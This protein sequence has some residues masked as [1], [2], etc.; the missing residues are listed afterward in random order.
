MS[1]PLPNAAFD[2]T[3]DLL[4][5]PY[6][7]IGRHC[8]RLGSDGFRT[9]IALRPAICLRGA[10]AAAFFYD[11]ERFGR[12]K[13]MPPVTVRLLQ[14]KGSVQTLNG[15]AHRHR[16][17]MF[18]DLATAP[19]RV[20]AME[21]AFGRAWDA[22]QERW[23]AAGEARLLPEVN[24]VLAR[25]A[26][27]WMGFGWAELGGHR[28]SRDMDAMV[29]NA[30]G[31]GPR[32]WAALMRR[33]RAERA[34][35]RQ[36]L[37]IRQGRH[38]AAE[39]APARKLAFFRD[40]TGELLAPEV[41]AVEALNLLRPTL[42]IGRFIVDAAQA[43]ERDPALR[44]ALVSDPSLTE[45]FAEEVRRRAR[46]FPLIGGTALRD[47]DWRGTPI[48]KGSWVLLALWG[49]S[50]DSRAIAGPERIDPTRAHS[51]REQ[52]HQV[53]PQGAGL[54]AETHRCPGEWFT[55]ALMAQATTRLLR[56]SYRVGPAAMKSPPFRYP[57]S[58]RD[59]FQMRDLRLR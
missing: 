14:D 51:W 36:I 2:L 13:A 8:D 45:G 43:L 16:K 41:A 6:G 5:D 44:A 9:R 20:A 59:G 7:F 32:S 40:E 23:L 3:L 35:R 34:V 11:G 42:A 17:A 25:A 19:D 31:M 26:V 37:A 28:F 55:V 47:L 1:R 12:A 56:L 4:R 58:P 54:S 49:T 52:G 24:L 50:N 38:P 46:Y 18:L 10:E 39:N 22:A 27:D 15:A 29:A 33:R 48:R 21:Q 30:A 57:P 53:I